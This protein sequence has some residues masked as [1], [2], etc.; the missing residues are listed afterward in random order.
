MQIPILSG[1]YVDANPAVRVSYP[2]NMV[3]VPGSNG[4]SDG[5]LRPAEGIDVF[6]PGQGAD[7]G[8]IVF[9][10]VHIRVS[11]QKLI[12]VSTMGVV[13][14]L[15]DIPGTD[16]ARL[17]Y[18]FDRLA[19]A[20]DNKLFY[21]NGAILTQVTDSDLG[22]V[23][24]VV[25]VDGFF[26]FTDG[27][28]IGVT[29]LTDPTSVNPL[30]FGSAEVDPDPIQCLLKV[31]N[32]VHAVGRN[33]IEVFSNTGGDFFP[34]TRI[35]T[36]LIPRGAVGRRAACVFID[37]VA[38]VGGARNEAPA[39]YLGRNA[40][41]VK[42]STREID[43]LLLEY[44]E[45]QLAAI[46][47]EVVVDRGSQFLYMHLPDRTLVYDHTA[48]ASLGSDRQ[49]EERPVWFTLTSTGVA[50]A[51]T[52]YRARNILRAG[53]A[54]IV[55]DPFSSTIGKWSTTSSQH[56]GADVWW[57]FGTLMLR[58]EG[59]GA[60]VNALELVA[61]TGDVPVGEDPM[62]STAYSLDGRTFSQERP[63]R[64]GKRGDATKRL[65]WFQQ[66]AWRNF[67][68]QRF[69]GDSGS[70]L[71]ALRLDAAIEALAY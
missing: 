63:I 8:S 38:F 13:A 15:G 12:S 2:V 10:G 40:Q 32:E 51:F 29:E 43:L 59:H 65:M 44:T 1:I 25:F 50:G 36:A 45:A 58:N 66:G 3:P 6:A 17:D 46:L 62:I 64:S 37:A 67:R 60:I 27:A 71:T 14:V 23:H 56:Y 69:R 53:D 31:L 54:W 28:A 26:M 30:K 57:E 21:W 7:R 68:I 48:T 39:V 4:V 61:L 41:T 47:L 20:A 70:R 55:G 33:T 49:P 9:Q 42:L 34:F 11:G 35:A 22:S 5:H 19:I 24:D 52:Q 18:S 16:L